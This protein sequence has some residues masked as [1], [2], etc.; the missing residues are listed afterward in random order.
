[1]H[2]VGICMER[3]CR[4]DG[5]LNQTELLVEAGGASERPLWGSFHL[6]NYQSST[7][8]PSTAPGISLSE[9]D[10]D[11][12]LSGILPGGKCSLS[13]WLYCSHPCPWL[14]GDLIKDWLSWGWLTTL[15]DVNAV[16]SLS[17]KTACSASTHGRGR[18]LWCEDKSQVFLSESWAPPEGIESSA[19]SSSSVLIL[20]QLWTLTRFS[21]SFILSTA[22]TKKSVQ[23][24]FLHVRIYKCIN[25]HSA[26]F[27]F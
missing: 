6:T 4:N 22:M 9:E 23:F 13:G 19:S 7:H 5:W 12:I 27:V 21:Y 11:A 24:L 15:M 10:D 20:G 16:T 18:P 14:S 1:M 17:M 2:S 3:C 8:L 26:E 25:F